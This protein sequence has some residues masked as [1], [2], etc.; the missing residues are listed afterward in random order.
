LGVVFRNWHPGPLLFQTTADALA[1]RYTAAMLLALDW[2][3]SESDPLTRW[4][5]EP[6]RLAASD[7]PRPVACPREWC[8]APSLPA[9]AYF[10]QPA[11]GKSAVEVLSVGNPAGR[12]RPGS[13]GDLAWTFDPSTP[14]GARVVPQEERD[15]PGC[16]HPQRCSGWA[17]PRGKQA[18]WLSFRLPELHL[19][20]VAICCGSKQCG[21]MMIDAGAELLID[22]K[23]PGQPP[24]PLWGGKC[25][26]VQAGFGDDTGVI[27]RDLTAS[28]RLPPMDTPL[29]PITHVF[30]L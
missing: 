15:L 6:S 12:D 7:L 23:P 29:P 5:R 21:Q 1:Y 2:I 8:T 17:V 9:C 20:L 27:P 4:P 25:I 19:G 18:G 11:F 13:G 14:A 28:I 10:Q 16:G 26:Q 30:G 22:G 24:S 3:E